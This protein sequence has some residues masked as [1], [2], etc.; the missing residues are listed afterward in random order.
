LIQS[1][2]K[3]KY[4]Y[5]G[6]GLGVQQTVIPTTLASAYGGTG[7]PDVE[8]TTTTTAMLNERHTVEP[9]DTSIPTTSLQ[10]SPSVAS[11]RRF[12]VLEQESVGDDNDTAA[13]SM[14]HFSSSRNS[15][16]T[17]STTSSGKRGR[18]SGTVALATIGH[19]I[20][21]LGASFRK[22]VENR[23]ARHND[24]MTQLTLQMQHQGQQME[25][26]ERREQMARQERQEA[27]ERAQEKESY[28][29][30]D[31]LATLFDVFQK[32]EGSATAYLNNLLEKDSLRK[33]WVKRKIA[34]APV[35]PPQ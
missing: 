24:I 13:K 9:Y 21:D 5:Q 29:S 31:D 27:M 32:E 11:K 33:A 23:E 17:R 22:S 8:S 35:L 15:L 19:G 25:R 10:P 18:M 3:G 34:L 16:S 6:N 14:S 4:S 20:L 30:D 1:R 7:A 28:L 12:S 26:Q 2:A